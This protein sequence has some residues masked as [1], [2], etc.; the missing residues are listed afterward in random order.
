MGLTKRKTMKKLNKIAML[1]ATAA[2]ASAAGAQT[3]DNWRNAGSDLVWKNGTNEHC[4]R[5]NF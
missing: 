2:V 3:I 4:W 5:D 1:I